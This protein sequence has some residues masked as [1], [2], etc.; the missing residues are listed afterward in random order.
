MIADTTARADAVQAATEPTSASLRRTIDRLP[1]VGW[2]FATLIVLLDTANPVVHATDEIIFRD[3]L[4]RMRTGLGYYPAMRAALAAQHAQASQV[5][6]FRLPTE[7]LLLR[8][9]PPSSYRILAAGVVLASVAL[10]WLL[11]RRSHPGVQLLVLVGSAMWLS[12]LLPAVYLYAEIWALPC[13]LAA[14]LFARRGR[15][16]LVAVALFGAVALRELYLPALLV[17]LAV[18]P[19]GRRKPLAIALAGAGV[20]GAVHWWLASQQLVAKGAEA[21]FDGFTSLAATVRSMLSPS[22]LLAI[23][24]PLAILTLLGALG[25]VR[26]WRLDPAARI[27]AV[28]T[29]ALVALTVFGGRVYW[30]L[31]YSPALV[32]FAGVPSITGP[33]DPIV[34]TG[35]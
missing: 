31:L 10:C 33:V 35:G 19:R 9:A 30:P 21:P 22:P 13:F 2:V 4:V 6:S 32:A 17:A 20:L 28:T 24:V 8:W 1:I 18:A 12:R 14:L 16:A 3:A 11:A 27:L 29:V 34:E 5:R 26:S 25:V 7:F 23:E 15:W